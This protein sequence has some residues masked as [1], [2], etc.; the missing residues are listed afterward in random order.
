MSTVRYRG[1][2]LRKYE[3]DILVSGNCR[4][5]F[6]PAVEYRGDEIALTVSHNGYIQ[7]TRM[8]FKN[9]LQPLNLIERV[10]SA[11]L[12]AGEYL[13]FPERIKIDL[14]TVYYSSA[15]DDVK[16]E[17]QAKRGPLSVNEELMNFT[18]HLKDN[19]AGKEIFLLDDLREYIGAAD[20]DLNEIRKY[21]RGVKRNICSAGRDPKV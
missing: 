14:S 2:D 7:G 15:Q 5:F 12:E 11:A 6:V 9:I 19:C 3:I 8:R 10:I 20:P 16:L 21:V 4:A 1:K 13:I 18:E 17:F